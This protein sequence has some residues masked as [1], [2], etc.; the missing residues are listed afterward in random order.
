MLMVKTKLKVSPIN[1]IGLFAD[2]FIPKG[3][4]V[5]QYDMII[6]RLYHKDELKFVSKP[7]RKMLDHYGYTNEY[8]DIILCGDDARFF[9]HSFIPNCFEQYS[10]GGTS[11][12]LA[13]R[14]I[15]R[16][17]EMTID[18]TTFDN[19]YKEKLKMNDQKKNIRK[20]KRKK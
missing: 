11:P 13:M 1:E 17:E 15:Q 9:N 3:T 5:W 10:P 6:D 2:E 14:D 16:G 8:N 19:S 18:Y 12:T 7:A 20:P 4:I